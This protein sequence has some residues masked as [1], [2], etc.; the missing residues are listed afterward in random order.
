MIPAITGTFGNDII[1][2][3]P[4][5]QT[6]IALAG[7]DIVNGGDGND[8]IRGNGGNDKLYGDNGNDTL[9]GGNGNDWLFGGKG[10][11]KLYGGTGDDVLSGG[12]GNDYLQGDE[13]ND[14]LYGGTGNDVLYGATGNDLLVGGAGNDVFFFK[15]TYEGTD[16]IQDFTI[17]E[18]KL[19]LNGVFRQVG[20]TGYA[21]A[22]ARGFL[23]VEQLSLGSAHTVIK[24]DADGSAGLG[25]TVT[26]A[27]LS[28][29][30]AALI[31]RSSFVA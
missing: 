30:N 27:V 22:I 20:A 18:D 3:N 12:D 10:N 15:N 29:T 21:D 6:I 5:S 11:D 9:S 19:N 24:I 8:D 14:Q 1:K 4:L 26:L 13:G 23:K 17:G 2:S 28:N 31:N 25:G 16:K 7:D